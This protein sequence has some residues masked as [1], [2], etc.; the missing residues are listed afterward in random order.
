MITFDPS[1]GKPGEEFFKYILCGFM[2]PGQT[3]HDDRAAHREGDFSIGEKHLYRLEVKQDERCIGGNHPTGNLVIEVDKP[4]NPRNKGWLNHCIDN[5][6]E[7][8]IY[9]LY[10][11]ENKITPA[12]SY[13]LP[14]ITLAAYIESKKASGQQPRMLY[15]SLV[16]IVAAQELIEQCGMELIQGRQ[17]IGELEKIMLP[18]LWKVKPPEWCT[19]IHTIKTP[20]GK[21][22][23]ILAGIMGECAEVTADDPDI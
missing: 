6:V 4:N 20:D 22:R 5:G 15:G 2:Y 13:S 17:Y 12:R 1:T 10:D 18:V 21:Y 14:V 9:C 11:G 8:I 3:L 19:E 23:L 7:E 16:Y